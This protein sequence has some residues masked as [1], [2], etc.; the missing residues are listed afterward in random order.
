MG[1]RFCQAVFGLLLSLG[2]L[3]EGYESPRPHTTTTP[4]RH[5]PISPP[6]PTPN[7]DAEFRLLL[8]FG[9]LAA[10]LLGRMRSVLEKLQFSVTSENYP[11]F[12]ECQNAPGKYLVSL[13]TQQD[14]AFWR[15]R[16]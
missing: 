5:R 16:S 13:G 12:P 2:R 10:C 6:D 7:A 14:L 8:F 4:H 11:G 3:P 1:L 9:L 15:W